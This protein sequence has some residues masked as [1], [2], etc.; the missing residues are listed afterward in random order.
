LS[1]S[2]T[3]SLTHI[4]TVT[5][6]CAIGDQRGRNLSLSIA[7][8]LARSRAGPSAR[9]L[10]SSFSPALSRAQGPHD[11][12]QQQTRPQYTALQERILSVT[13]NT[14]CTLVAQTHSPTR[15]HIHTGSMLVK[16]TNKPLGQAINGNCH[17]LKGLFSLQMC[18]NGRQCSNGMGLG[19]RIET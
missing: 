12:A 10:F 5:R 19:C 3:Y 13:R 8:S 11:A 15:K 7:R 6:A 14:N 17:R 18:C 9:A 1:H 2:S 4:H 16:G